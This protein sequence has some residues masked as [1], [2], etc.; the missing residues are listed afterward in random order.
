MVGDRYG[1]ATDRVFY[2][3]AESRSLP[4]LDVAEL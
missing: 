1:R 2:A 3:A 4:C